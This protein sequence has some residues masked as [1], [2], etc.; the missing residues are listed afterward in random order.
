M[1]RPTINYCERAFMK[2]FQQEQ[3]CP[4]DKLC[5]FCDQNHK[6]P[7]YFLGFYRSGSACRV[8]TNTA[9]QGKVLLPYV[10][11]KTVHF[12]S[13]V[14]SKCILC[15]SSCRGL[16]VLRLRRV[17][18]VLDEPYSQLYPLSRAAVQARQSA[19]AETGSILCS[20][21]GRHGYLR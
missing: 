17:A 1:D 7:F 5:K 18:G 4:V 20:L 12:L 3:P 19:K 6:M 9:T 21:A 11:Y 16:I 14:C 10:P 8:D 2:D 13:S 15:W